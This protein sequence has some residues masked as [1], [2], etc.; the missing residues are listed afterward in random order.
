MII[1]RT[2]TLKILVEYDGTDY[3]GWQSQ[4][5]GGT[6]QDTLEAAF[7]RILNHPVRIVGSGRTDSGVHALGQVAHFE[8]TSIIELC[9]LQRGVNSLLPADIL[10][11]SVDAVDKNFHAR[12]SARSRRYEY[13]LWNAS[14]PSVF[15]RRFTWWI[16]NALD[17]EAMHA[18][19]HLLEGAHDFS[20]FQAAG[21]HEGSAERNVLATGLWK[22]GPTVIFFIHA[23]AFLRHMVRNI[24]GTLVE[25]GEKKITSD[26]FAA[27]FDARDRT[28]AGMTAPPQ[29]LFLT[30]V[31]Y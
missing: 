25:V 7:S 8:T 5:G 9:A 29:G 24:V 2:R 26:D 31:Y 1:M 11:K 6:I 18:A 21:D 10:I 30:N 15:R 3:Y 4:R 22:D 27:I 14:L 28:K 19:A 17:L 20:S 13:H 16:R 12:F 23:N